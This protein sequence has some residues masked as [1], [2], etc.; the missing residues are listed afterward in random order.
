MEAKPKT[1][2]E[3]IKAY[4]NIDFAL[5]EATDSRWPKGVACAHCGTNSPM[6]LK[7]R[8][9][10]KCSKCRKQFSFKA[11][12]LLEDS[13]IGLNKWLPAIWM[14]ANARNGIGSHEL[15]RAI[16]VTQK[17]AWFILHRIRLA[18]QD[19]RTGG[20]LDGEV[21]IDESFIGGKARNMHKGSLRRQMANEGGSG[22][23]IVLGMLERGGKVRAIHVQ[24]RSKPVLHSHV[25]Q[26]VEAGAAIFTDALKSYD[27][28]NEFEHKVVDHAVEYVRG[29]VHTNTMENFWSLLK[30]DL[31][32]TYISVEPFH[33]FRY[34]DEQAFRYNNRRHSDGEVVSDYERFKAALGQV[35]GRRL[36]YRK[37]TA[38]EGETTKF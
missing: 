34:L 36:T 35:T 26:N 18:M 16:G 30:R 17:T 25:R 14:I 31:K 11:G 20:K 4:E 13:P 37:L 38:K 9:I 2:L 5:G 23:E 8:K 28:L 22:K 3:A 21:E 15:G 6:F 24:K 10:W 1:L 27:D 33:L 32:G 7:T 29:N 19:E 12:T